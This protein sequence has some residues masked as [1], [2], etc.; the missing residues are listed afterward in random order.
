[1]SAC[2]QED[3]QPSLQYG[4]PARYHSSAEVKTITGKA[5][6][7]DRGN[8]DGDPATARFGS[9][10]GLAFDSKGNLFITDAMFNT[11]RVMNPSGNVSTFAGNGKAG[12]VDGIGTNASFNAP[13]GIAIDAND[14]IYVAD[15]YNNC[16]RKITAAGEVTTF[17][18][19]ID[20]LEDNVDGVGTAARFVQPLGLTLD[21]QDN[22]YVAGYHNIRKIT[23][24]GEVTTL[25]GNDYNGYVDGTGVV[26]TFW[27]PIGIAVGP[28]KNIYVAD[29]FN[30]RI[31]KITPAGVV[32]TFAGSDSY[33][34]TDGI[35]TAATFTAPYGIVIDASGTLYIT[36][37][38]G[39]IRKVTA[40]SVVTT[41]AGGS[42]SPY[43]LDG[44]GNLSSFGDPRGIALDASGNLYVTDECVIRKIILK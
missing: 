7:T 44:I 4:I 43:V 39:F 34:H 8:I 18:G 1:M 36:E 29:N 26:A 11:I 3:V 40:D 23:S 5:G 38:A 33:L 17:A 6:I 25:A 35:G 14:N 9:L 42:G 19:S 12:H 27:S 16:I 10:N 20:G 41:I 32:T 37:E 28:D 30:A 24:S 31:R 13:A 21:A 2:E 15:S 22:L